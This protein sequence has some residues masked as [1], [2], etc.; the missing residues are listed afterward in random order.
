M[1]LPLE[2]YGLATV[3]SHRVKLANRIFRI[4]FDGTRQSY[5]LYGRDESLPVEDYTGSDNTVG[6]LCVCGLGTKR[7]FSIEI[8]DKFCFFDRRCLFHV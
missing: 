8:P 1:V 4:L 5:W 3:E 7:A 6:V 2:K